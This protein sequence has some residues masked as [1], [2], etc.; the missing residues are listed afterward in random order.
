MDGRSPTMADASVDI[1]T[2]G[3]GGVLRPRNRADVW[4]FASALRRSYGPAWASRGAV[5]TLSWSPTRSPS[6]TGSHM[7]LCGSA[8][9]ISAAATRLFTIAIEASAEWGRV[10]AGSIAADGGWR[11]YSSGP[12]LYVYLLIRHAFG[13]HRR[14]GERIVEPG[15]PRV[16]ERPFVDWAAANDRGFG[17]ALARRVRAAAASMSRVSL[18]ASPNGRN[19]GRRDRAQDARRG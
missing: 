8:T 10:R 16:A 17:Q 11:I 9:P 7:H 14:F 2:S 5:E 13:V 4:P 15:L 19:T 12:G 3:I 6:P 1:P 18:A